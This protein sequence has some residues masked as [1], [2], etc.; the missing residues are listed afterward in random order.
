M[1]TIWG[2]SFFAMIKF[3]MG[4]SVLPETK[5]RDEEGYN[6]L[7]SIFAKN[8]YGYNTRFMSDFDLFLESAMNERFINTS[9][10]Y[11]DDKIVSTEIED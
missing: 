4:Q 8:K 2:F 11:Y 3:L 10:L 5:E 6:R 7:V 1:S 9:T